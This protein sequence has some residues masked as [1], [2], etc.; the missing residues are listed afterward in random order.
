ML[1][2][3]NENI[4]LSVE[5]DKLAVNLNLSQRYIKRNPTWR[6]VPNENFLSCKA[7]IHSSYFQTR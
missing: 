7:C 1:V 5:F 3:L 2:N 4:G 6:I